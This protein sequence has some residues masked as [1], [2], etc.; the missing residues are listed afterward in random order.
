MSL[1]TPLIRSVIFGP[2]LFSLEL[3]QKTQW[4]E[5]FYE[6]GALKLWSLAGPRSNRWAV[7]MTR[8]VL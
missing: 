4:S 1:A 2:T 7:D 6:G 5:R 8:S 3:K